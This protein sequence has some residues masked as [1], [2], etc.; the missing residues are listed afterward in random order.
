MT[1]QTCCR[2]LLAVVFLWTASARAQEARGVTPEPQ[3]EEG[4]AGEDLDEVVAGHARR[5]EEAISRGQFAVAVAEL[6]AA[7]QMDPQPVFLLRA[8]QAYERAGQHREALAMYREFLNKEPPGPRRTEAEAA[9]RALQRRSAL[10]PPI[11]KQGWFW[12][13][14]GGVV[15]VGAGLGLGLGLGLRSSATID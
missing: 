1:L 14:V 7:Y 5:A 10:R 4:E 6:Q 9:M 15:V 3:L 2:W 8:A 11:W 12:A 13:L